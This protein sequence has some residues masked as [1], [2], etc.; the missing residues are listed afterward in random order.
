MS[1]TCTVSTE[2]DPPEGYAEES[3]AW[4]LPLPVAVTARAF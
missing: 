2:L 1:R 3:V 4:S